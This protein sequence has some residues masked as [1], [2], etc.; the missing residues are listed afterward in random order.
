M[1][2]ARQ[3]VD[4]A[5][6]NPRGLTCDTLSTI[7]GDNGSLV[8]SYDAALADLGRRARALRILRDLPQRELARRA[9]VGEAT[10]KRFERSGRASVENML[11]L[12]VALGVEE[13]FDR[14]FELPKY[15][16]LDEALAQP[17]AASRRR[18]R[19]RR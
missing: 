15:R 6:R 5:R 9:G 10:V 1:A 2:A 17:A 18:V 8:I 13:G 4:P 12:A 16:T 3:A 19:S 14:L 7:I 11:R